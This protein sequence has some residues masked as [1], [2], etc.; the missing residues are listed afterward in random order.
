[1][2]QLNLRTIFYLILPTIL[3][4]GN[5]V[6]GRLAVGEVS[7]LLLNTIRWVLAVKTMDSFSYLNR[8]YCKTKTLT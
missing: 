3:W 6:V 5:A 7:P 4:A 1:M 8:V 2:T